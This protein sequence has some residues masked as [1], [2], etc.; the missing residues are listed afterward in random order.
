MLRLLPL[1][2]HVWGGLGSQLHAW[3]LAENLRQKSRRSVGF[4]LHTSG[5]TRRTSDIDFLASEFSIEH[6]EDF[7]ATS[8]LS[9][10]PPRKS[11]RSLTLVKAFIKFT[12]IVMDDSQLEVGE[13]VRPWTIAIRGH[14]TKL[15]VDGKI[16]NQIIGK[17]KEAGFLNLTNFS[18]Q[19]TLFHYRLGD[20]LELVDKKPIDPTRIARIAAL[21]RPYSVLSDSPEIASEW[22]SLAIGSEVRVLHDTSAWHALQEAVTAN[23]FVGTPSKISFWAIAIRS[24]VRENS[25][26]YITKEHIEHLSFLIPTKRLDEIK[27][28]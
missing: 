16:L 2:I 27:S 5:V 21:P 3:A 26:S 12:R 20:L 18:T 9:A 23:V 15:P 22:L 8:S 14:Y 25:L 7:H 6:V 4:I 11:G 1:K 28:Y 19:G 17:A 24:S 13:N 10:Q